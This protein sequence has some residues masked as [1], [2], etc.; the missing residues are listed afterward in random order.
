MNF[1]K[2][3][4]KVSGQPSEINSSYSKNANLFYEK[5]IQEENA[6]IENLVNLLLKNK[7][8]SV[9]SG[10]IKINFEISRKNLFTTYILPNGAEINC[11]HKYNSIFANNNP[12][13]ELLLE[14][15]KA[16]C[17][18][19]LAGK[20]GELILYRYPSIGFYVSEEEAKQLKF[21]LRQLAKRSFLVRF[22]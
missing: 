7:I 2:N 14:I 5:K 9:D 16:E 3:A 1:R 20:T 19:A 18:A 22:K 15:A 4:K 17:N 11:S 12:F 21:R 8:T 13:L 10:S 6:R